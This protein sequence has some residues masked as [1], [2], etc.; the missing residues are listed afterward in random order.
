MRWVNSELQDLGTI[1]VLHLTSRL[2]GLLMAQSGSDCALASCLRS[3]L[4][5][6]RLVKERDVSGIAKCAVSPHSAFISLDERPDCT[7]RFCTLA[8]AVIFF[9]SFFFSPN[10]LDNNTDC[11]FSQL[12]WKNIWKIKS[13]RGAFNLF[14]IVL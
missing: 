9:R 4:L 7:S 5:W 8:A 3:G 1:T 2:A 13:I 10:Q 14:M 12:F 6:G 11:V